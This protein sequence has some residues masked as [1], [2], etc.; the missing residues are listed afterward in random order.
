M[1]KYISSNDSFVHIGGMDNWK[2]GQFNYHACAKDDKFIYMGFTKG[3]IY[4]NPAEIRQVSYNNP[5]CFHA[6]DFPDHPKESLHWHDKGEKTVTLPYNRNFFSIRFSVAEMLA[7]EEI[8]FACYM[9][10]FEEDWKEIGT[11][12]QVSY[13]NVPPG[14]YTFHVKSTDLSGHWNP[15]VSSLQIII[16]PPWWQTG[17]AWCLWTLLIAGALFSAAREKLFPLLHKTMPQTPCPTPLV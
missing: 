12:R 2:N 14:K 3:L 11:D 7:P 6:L 16:T 15:E 17:W 1:Y 13:T 4:F 9:E 8:Q 10:G 5:V